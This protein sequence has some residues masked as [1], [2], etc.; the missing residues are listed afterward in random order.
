[1]SRGA[2]NYENYMG[3]LAF[4]SSSDANPQSSLKNM[5]LGRSW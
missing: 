1:M 5:N 4:G 3:D 2:E